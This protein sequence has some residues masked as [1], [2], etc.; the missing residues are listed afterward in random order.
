MSAAGTIGIKSFTRP[1]MPQ[2]LGAHTSWQELPCP[3]ER[4]PPTEEDES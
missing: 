1:S 3:T 2:T 4:S